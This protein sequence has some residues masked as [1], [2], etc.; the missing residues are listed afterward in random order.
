MDEKKLEI[1]NRVA[2]DPSREE[3]EAELDELVDLHACGVEAEPKWCVY[4]RHYKDEGGQ[5]VLYWILPDQE[6]QMVAYKI[7]KLINQ[8]GGKASAEMTEWNEDLK[9]KPVYKHESF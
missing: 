5:G 1:V 4:G 9:G 6:S 7:A 2:G 3:K 8:L